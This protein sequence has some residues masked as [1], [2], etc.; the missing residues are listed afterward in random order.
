MLTDV[1]KHDTNQIHL[2]IAIA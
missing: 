2:L 1:T